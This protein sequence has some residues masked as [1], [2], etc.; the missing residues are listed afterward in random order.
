MHKYRQTQLFAQFVYFKAAVIV[1]LKILYIWVQFY[2]VQ[3]QFGKVFDVTLNIAAV[4]V[5]C[6]KPY[7]PPAAFFTS[8]AINSFML[9]LA[10]VQLQ[11]IEL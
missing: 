3:S 7:K 10:L 11:P 8:A 1:N 4:G 5:Q 6:A 9:L 2:A